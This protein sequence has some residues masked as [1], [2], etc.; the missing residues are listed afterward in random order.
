MAGG[1]WTEQSKTLPG[2]YINSK[3]QP[4]VQS[5]FGTRGTVAIAQA[6]S[7]GAPGEVVTITPGE[8][9]TP[10]IGYEI[11]ADEAQALREMMRGTDV[12][13]GPS[14][15]LLYRKTGTGG[16]K[17]SATIG[18]LIATAAYIGTRGNSITI[19]VT[20]DPDASGSFDVETIVDG[21][22][23]DTQ[24]VTAIS[25]LEANAW[26][27]FSGTGAITASAG[28]MLSG[29]VDPTVAPADDAA[30]LTAIE[31]YTFDVIAY[32]GDSA[33]VQ[34]SYATFVKR[35]NEEIGKKCQLVSC[36]L[37][38]AYDSKYVILAL[39]G[40]KLEDGSDITPSKAVW[41]L[42][43]AEAGALY[44]EDLTYAQYPTA[45]SASPKLTYAQQEA[46]INAGLVAFIDDF[47]VVK[48]LEDIN[49]KTTVTAA[50]GAEF[51]ENRVMRVI[52]QF[53]NDAYRYYSSYVLGKV[54]NIP[55]GRALLRGWLIGYLN[56]MQGN[57]GIQNFAAEDV[58]VEAGEQPDGVLINAAIQPVRSIK[59]IYINAIV[60][61]TGV[62][63]T[64]A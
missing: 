43:G 35:M 39:N 2:V 26:V 45:V 11:G 21:Q 38:T 31:P 47:D 8:D 44:N 25:G 34:A 18:N 27:V 64:V 7:W 24:T 29:G 36:D 13:D 17:A 41:W 33:T 46:A 61:A 54:D 55:E 22:V 28:V 53:C 49:N 40:V 56:D 50:E 58:T 9:L 6:L 20:A 1:I 30:F 57:N 52:M 60:N 48:V 63:V 5:K 19:V 16:V 4:Q 51:K 32:D 3:S 14:K 42:A 23:V 15:I 10:Y 37:Q 59:K 62:T 12:S